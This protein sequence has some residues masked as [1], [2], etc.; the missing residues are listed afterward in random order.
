MIY[1]IS[2]PKY[3]SFLSKKLTSGNKSF[4]P[5]KRE[6]LDKKAGPTNEDGRSG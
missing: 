6:K 1:S 2:S 3:Q 4:A 5:V